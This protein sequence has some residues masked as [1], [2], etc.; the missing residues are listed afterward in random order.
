MITGTRARGL[1]CRDAMLDAHPCCT[2]VCASPLAHDSRTEATMSRGHPDLSPHRSRWIE[3]LTCVTMLLLV[4]TGVARS[5]VEIQTDWSGG[6]GQTD[7]VTEWTDRFSEST[8]ASWRAIPGQVAL[9]SLP[10]NPTGSQLAQTGPTCES[11]GAGDLDGDGDVDLITALPIDSGSGRVFWF[12]N[13]GDGESFTEHEVDDDFYGGEAV[14]AADLDGDGDLDIVASAFYDHDPDDRNGRYVWYENDQGDASV[15]TKHPISGLHWGTEMVATADIDGDGDLDVY[16]ASTLAYIGNTNDD[17]YWFENLD[18]DG[19]SWTQRTIDA[20]FDNAT[21]A[22]AADID[23]DGDLDVACNSYGTHI[24]AWWENL[25]GD[26]I[27]WVQHNV[28]GFTGLDNSLDVGDLDDDGDLDIAATGFN[29]LEAGWFENLDGVGGSWAPHVMGDFVKGKDVEI[30]D[31]DGDGVLDVLLTNGDLDESIVGWFR[32]NGGAESWS[33][34][35]VNQGHDD[36]EAAISADLD[37]DGA[38]EVVYTEG[39]NFNGDVAGLHGRDIAF[40]WGNGEL[41]SSVLDAGGPTDWLAVDWDATVP[42]QTTLAFQVR[43]S[44]DP[45]DLG[46][47]SA[48]ISSPGS[49]EGILDPGTRYVQ[50]RMLL[51]TD[52]TGRSPRVFEVALE[53]QDPASAPDGAAAAALALEPPRPN[54]AAG[55]SR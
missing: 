41:I 32:N 36:G 55:A 49:I 16:G 4:A 1:L 53:A 9:G 5:G 39:G 44:N 43:S 54:P 17:L 6:P 46:P 18:G 47:W 28:T 37:G 23:G 45:G 31:L 20:S 33:G 15:W 14:G 26:G 21:D 2:L 8:R 51:S 7:P 13:A 34:F 48:E 30:A 19:E 50:V 12:E 52:D 3:S 38:L 10:G 27:D 22:K 11:V 40:F 25:E 35:L 24:L 29:A 42:P